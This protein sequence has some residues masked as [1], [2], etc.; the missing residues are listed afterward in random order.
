MTTKAFGNP[1]TRHAHGELATIPARQRLVSQ[2]ARP[3]TI[4]PTAPFSASVVALLA[5][6]A[7]AARLLGRS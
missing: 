5:L 3:T 4:N 7:P 2:P 1:Y 6:I